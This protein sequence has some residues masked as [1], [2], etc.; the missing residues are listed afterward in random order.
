MTW[1][2]LALSL[3]MGGISLAHAQD[4]QRASW[5]PNESTVPRFVW[6]DERCAGCSPLAA[7]AE[8]K[9]MESLAG[10]EDIRFLRAKGEENGPAWSYAPGTVVLSPQTLTLPDCQLAFVVG[11]ELVHIAQR[12][13]DEDAHDVSVLSGMPP[14][15]T[16]SGEDAI[17]LLDGD[18]PLAWRMSPIW[19]QQ[20][21]E[22]DW[23]GSLLAAQACGCSLEEGALAYLGADPEAGGGIISAHGESAD[24]VRFL[25]N[26]VES[27][28]RL[29]SRMH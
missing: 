16:R 9:A 18:F 4:P 6:T 2:C 10:L 23:V 5:F 8:W 14:A 24:R 7:R 26:F 25:E 17:A 20:E 12:H 21:Q 11:H 28:K 29:A 15:W 27:A 13:F 3:G 1:C 22:A 19:Q